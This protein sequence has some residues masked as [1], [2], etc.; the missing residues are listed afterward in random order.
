MNKSVVCY[1]LGFQPAEVTVSAN[2]LAAAYDVASF[3]SEG[4][5]VSQ[6]AMSNVSQVMIEELP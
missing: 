5:A 6:A 2:A 3:D 4:C 1:G